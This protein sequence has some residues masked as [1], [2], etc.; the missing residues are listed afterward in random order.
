MML[1]SWIKSRI[2]R[3]L[4]PLVAKYNSRNGVFAIEI[5]SCVRL[6]AKLEWCLGILAHCDEN[7]PIPQ[8]KFSY[9]NSKNSEDYFGTFFGQ[10]GVGYSRTTR[11][12]SVLL[13]ET[14]LK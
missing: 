8:F 3:A 7:G 12:L 10:A 5:K 14:G 6:V 13:A 2:N 4:I 11:D 1:F 9:P